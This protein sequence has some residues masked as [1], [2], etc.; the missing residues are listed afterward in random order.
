MSTA[1]AAIQNT[2]M[3]VVLGIVLK[4]DASSLVYLAVDVRRIP[5][6]VRPQTSSCNGRPGLRIV[7]FR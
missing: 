3:A 5:P 6:P 1:N 2:T 4:K 7:L